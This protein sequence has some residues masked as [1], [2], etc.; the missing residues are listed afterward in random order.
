MRK[1]ATHPFFCIRKWVFPGRLSH[2]L[3]LKRLEPKQGLFSH[4]HFLISGGYFTVQGLISYVKFLILMGVLLV[5]ISQFA[6]LSCT[7]VCF[8]GMV[9]GPP[10]HR[11]LPGT[12]C[13][14]SACC[15]PALRHPPTCARPCAF[16]V[17]FLKRNFLFWGA[18]LVFRPHFLIFLAWQIRV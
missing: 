8:S 18:Y 3:M 6:C 10:A 13:L 2:F 14:P 11:R 5:C 7:L 12:A 9:C 4:A 1:E 17:C 16:R 15:L